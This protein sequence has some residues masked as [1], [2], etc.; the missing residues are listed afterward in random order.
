MTYQTK[1]HSII[2]EA[3]YM[4]EKKKF[5]V[6]VAELIDFETGDIITYSSNSMFPDEWTGEDWGGSN[7]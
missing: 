7:N 2:L 6:P 5:V 1:L 3:H 4:E